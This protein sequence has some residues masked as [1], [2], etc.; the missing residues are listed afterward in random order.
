MSCVTGQKFVGVFYALMH[1]DNNVD[2][3]LQLVRFHYTIFGPTDDINTFE[4]TFWCALGPSW[5]FA[6][7]YNMW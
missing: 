5:Y 2:I 4:E 6:L 3:A 7:V 1:W